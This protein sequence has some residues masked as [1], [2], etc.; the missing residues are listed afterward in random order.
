METSIATRSNLQ[1]IQ[2]A[3]ANFAEGKI[4][5]I[6]DVCAEDV[7]WGSYKVPGIDI[8]G[9]FFGKEGVQ[10]F[11]TRLGEQ[12]HYSYFEPKEFIV[13]GDTVIVLGHHTGTVRSTGRSFDH[14]WCFS[15]K[16]RHGKLQQYFAF[17]D[18][19]EQARAFSKTDS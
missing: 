13:Q 4:S 5:A 19:Y 18:T 17:T 15:F 16:M 9:S 7:V 10:E 2:Q 8:T 12:I 1:I 11:F 6:V 14:D 3:F